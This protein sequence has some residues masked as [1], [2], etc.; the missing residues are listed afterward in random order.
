[1]SLLQRTDEL[2][3]V[4]TLVDARDPARA[5]RLAVRVL[6]DNSYEGA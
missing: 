2:A 3:L 6:D 5:F 1:L 4:F